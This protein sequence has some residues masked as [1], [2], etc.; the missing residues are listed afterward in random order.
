MLTTLGV[1]MLCF[2][3]YKTHGLLINGRQGPAPDVYEQV[4]PRSSG[5]PKT[6]I[7]RRNGAGGVPISLGIWGQGSLYHGGSPY[8]A[9][10]GSAAIAI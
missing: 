3:F 10:T 1:A 6:L 5:V 9:Y 7:A 2:S 8:R 4:G